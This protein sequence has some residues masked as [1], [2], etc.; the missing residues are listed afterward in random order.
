MELLY[1]AANMHLTVEGFTIATT[2]ILELQ[3]ADPEE[4][5]QS[6]ARKNL[7]MK[8]SNESQIQVIRRNETRRTTGLV[9]ADSMEDH[10][11]HGPGAAVAPHPN[12]KSQEISLR[13]A[14]VMNRGKSLVKERKGSH[15]VVGADQDTG[16]GPSKTNVK[17]RSGRNEASGITERKVETRI[18]RTVVVDVVVHFFTAGILGA[19]AE[20]TVNKGRKALIPRRS[21]KK[22]TEAMAPQINK[23]LTIRQL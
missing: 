2:E 12:G 14:R 3:D 15:R 13:K 5:L 22:E 19:L 4:D 6:M 21:V 16:P 17:A 11:L 9:V 10:L 20:R 8:K 1:R 18:H 23:H 7:L